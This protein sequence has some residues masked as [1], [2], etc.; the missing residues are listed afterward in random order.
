[1]SLKVGVPGGIITKYPKNPIFRFFWL[2]IVKLYDTKVKIVPLPG[3]EIGRSS[4][5]A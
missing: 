4:E 3:A 5:F 1:M 2:K